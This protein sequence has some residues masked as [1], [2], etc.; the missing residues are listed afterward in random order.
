LNFIRVYEM[1]GK[2]HREILRD[3]LAGAI[4][5][6]LISRTRRPKEETERAWVRRL[7]HQV[8]LTDQEDNLHASELP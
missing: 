2:F 6:R 8:G 3:V 4:V 5:H 7:M 1:D